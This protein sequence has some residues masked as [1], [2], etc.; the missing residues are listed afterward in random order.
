MFKS[1][2]EILNLIQKNKWAL[3]HWPNADG[4]VDV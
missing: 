2:F 1:E 3:A 4:D